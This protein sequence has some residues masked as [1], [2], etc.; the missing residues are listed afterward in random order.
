MKRESQVLWAADDVC[1]RLLRI[2][3]FL[4]LWLV[5]IEEWSVVIIL[6]V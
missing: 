2:G 5:E 1:V 3:M 4:A 6:P